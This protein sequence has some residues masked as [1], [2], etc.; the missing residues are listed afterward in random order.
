MTARRVGRSVGVSLPAGPAGPLAEVDGPSRAEL[1]AIEREW[2]LI[3]ADLAVLDAELAILTADGEVTDLAWR[4]LT[5]ARADAHAARP[6]RAAP[7]RQ[8]MKNGA[9]RTVHPL[10]A[11]VTP[12]GIHVGHLHE[13]TA[14]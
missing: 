8:A 14:S 11:R 3:A 2:P 1:A 12:S 10:P 6:L 4:R 13:G 5:H 9:R 7:R